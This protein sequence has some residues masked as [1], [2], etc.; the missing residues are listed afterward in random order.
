MFT[1][2]HPTA[3]LLIKTTVEL[4]SQK[5]PEQI[6]VEE[7]LH[8]S[9]ISKGSLYH[10]FQ[11]L[12]DLV[13]NALVVRYAAWVDNSIELIVSVLLNSKS[14]DEVRDGIK[15]ITR[16]TQDPK[17]AAARYERIQAIAGVQGNERYSKAL[18]VE[19]ERLTEALADLIRESISR[20]FF[21]KDL[22]PRTVAVFIQSYT[23]GKVVDDFVEKPMDPEKWNLLIDTVVDNVFLA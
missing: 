6:S 8:I 1:G 13:E 3:Q 15:A 2:K 14:I 7:I 23:I 11:D 12:N 5:R 20:G 22:D 4:L 9:G 19:Q 17:V 18:A 10:H 21:K 16:A